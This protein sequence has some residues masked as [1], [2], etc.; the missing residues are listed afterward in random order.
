MANCSTFRIEKTMTS[1]EAAG[2]DAS[3]AWFSLDTNRDVM[4]VLADLLSNHHMFFAG[5]SKGWRHAWGKRPK[6]TKAISAD[7]CLLYT[8]DAAD[9]YPV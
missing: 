6:T 5:V 1:T 9:V 3:G 2:N 4:T 8:S 7:T